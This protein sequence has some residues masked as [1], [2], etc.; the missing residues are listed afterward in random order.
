MMA[1]R[2]NSTPVPVSQKIR[3]IALY[4]RVS[5]LNGQNPELQLAE[6][7]EYA[8]RRGWTVAGEYIDLCVS[9]A[10]ES[11]PEF[12]RLMADAHRRR[13]DAIACWKLDRLGRS[14]KHLVLTLEDLQAYGVAFLALRDNLDLS[15]PSGPPHVPCCGR[16]GRV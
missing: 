5:T 7:R 4:A 2:H 15:T 8:T 1:S 6:L 14:L 16:Y 3:S 10:K 11:W 9:G 12:N 13:F